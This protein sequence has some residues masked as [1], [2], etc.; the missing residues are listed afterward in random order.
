MSHFLP[1]QEGVFLSWQP[2]LSATWKIGD[3]WQMNLKGI[4]FNT[5]AEPGNEGTVA[6]YRFQHL[7]FSAMGSYRTFHNQTFSVG[8]LYRWI[9]PFEKVEGY[10]HRIMEQVGFIAQIG[11]T[12]IA[13]RIRLEQRRRKIGLIHRWRYRLSMDIPLDGQTLNPNEMYLIISD[14]LL[15]SF[16]KPV[17]NFGENRLNGGLG[18]YFSRKVKCEI[19]LQYRANGILADNILHVLMMFTTCYFNF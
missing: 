16:G 9:E 18:W 3:R 1:A 5:F 11:A 10:E 6:N 15:W 12:R 2:E 13:N 7:D 17:S 4:A 14:E 8:Y 19:Q